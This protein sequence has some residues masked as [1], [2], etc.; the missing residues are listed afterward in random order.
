MTDPTASSRAQLVLPAARPERTLRRGPATAVG[1]LTAVVLGAGVVLLPGDSSGTGDELTTV[2]V[3]QR[4]AH[5]VQPGVPEPTTAAQPALQFR[6]PFRPLVS[7]AGEQAPVTVP[8]APVSA[9]D[10]G[11]PPA[12][13]PDVSFEPPP[14]PDFD[15]DLDLPQPPEALPAPPG[16]STGTPP[17]G[18][19]SLVGRQLSLTRVEA[20]GEDFVAVLSLDGTPSRVAVGASFGPGGELLLLSLQQGPVDGQWT[21]VVQ[22][23]RAEPFD[24]VTGTPVRLR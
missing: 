18:G 17:S 23:G 12:D 8:D 21:A 7:D 24:V 6:D 9:P 10:F 11:T 4:P 15:F 16:T 1:L 5:P 2:A 20:A 22:R 19:A 13:D 3:V 14:A